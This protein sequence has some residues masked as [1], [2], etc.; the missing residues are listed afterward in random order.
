MKILRRGGTGVQ[1]AC[2]HL[3]SILNSDNAICPS[4]QMTELQLLLL[5]LWEEKH[6][7]DVLMKFSR[8]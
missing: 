6:F 1:Y 7:T 4:N 3:G 2:N 8:G 5:L